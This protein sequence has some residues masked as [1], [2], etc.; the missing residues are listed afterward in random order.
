[1]LKTQE[2]FA[3][4]YPDAPALTDQFPEIE[5][6]CRIASHEHSF[7]RPE[8]D[9]QFKSEILFADS[10]FFNLFTYR[11]IEGNPITALA[12][13]DQCVLTFSTARKLFGEEDPVGKTVLVD[14]NTHPYTVAAVIADF[15][16]TM[17]R[18]QTGMLLRMEEL[19][20]FT[21]WDMSDQIR[22]G[23]KSSTKTFLLEKENAD[24]YAK[25]PQIK[26]YLAENSP[27][28]KY[29]IM[30]EPDLIA[31]NE[32]I[33][34][35]QNA[36]VKD[37]GLVMGDIKMVRILISIALAILLF[38]VINYINLTVAQTGMR[39]KEMA[40]RKLLGA[41]GR[42][43]T[44]R[45]I[46]ESVLMTL[47][48]ALLALG[49]AVGLQEKA[50]ALF[51]GSI[52]I[53]NDLTVYTILI[54]LGCI[55][56]LGVVSGIIPAYAVSRYE[57]IDIVKGSL[58]FRSKMVSGRLFIVLQ[59][60][61]TI[62]LIAA[63]ITIYCQINHLVHAPLGFRTKNIAEIAYAD[64]STLS[65]PGYD[66]T[67]IFTVANELRQL[68]FIE[69][70]G[71]SD[72]TLSGTSVMW[73]R[74]SNSEGKSYTYAPIQC[75]RTYAF[76]I[77]GLELLRDNHPATEAYYPDQA[78]ME[79]YGLPLDTT[80]L[81]VPNMT[82]SENGEDVT[83]TTILG[84]VIKNVHMGDI[85]RDNPA[86]LMKIVD[87]T[88]DNEQLN[89]RSV[90]VKLRDNVDR[91]Q[92][93][94]EMLQLFE[95]VTGSQGQC[96]FVEDISK[97]YFTKERDLSTIVVMFTIIALLI[98]SLGLL[99]MST[100]FTRRRL[101]EI[102]VR[103]IFGSTTKEVVTLLIWTFIRPMIISFAIALP[104]GWI[105]MERWLTS[106]SYR[107]SV[108]LWMFIAAGAFSFLIAT[109]TVL[110]QTLAAAYSNPVKSLKAE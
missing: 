40:S 70:V 54:F 93:V 9:A 44:L 58:K 1:M 6:F 89:V 25:L 73:A 56:L 14:D 90:T 86:M 21:G 84:G 34:A 95:S 76:D 42:E 92:A 46:G 55:I 69:N 68:S 35:P 101:S 67:K 103:K 78:Y 47:L 100:Y 23:G 22:I 102:G 83:V 60:I 43:I 26:T 57:P 97:E 66:R 5:S 45:F 11:F 82:S 37:D 88:P 30:K 105:V 52:S 99:A 79:M 18:P 27:P 28:F 24:L 33:F 15:D 96:R 61:I 10:T 94:K 17:I 106:Y 98:S 74:S 80:A 48:A 38:A 49:L 39:A 32:V 85:I 72:A 13:R 2:G 50:S 36:V 107:I 59:N 81:S 109:L 3:S 7:L 63:S 53:V 4:F 108:H 91:K 77:Y 62:V 41:S 65:L 64:E 8:S 29:A 31:L 75:D 20:V 110:W 104:I 71:L 16:R 51:G 87:F 19:P 12:A